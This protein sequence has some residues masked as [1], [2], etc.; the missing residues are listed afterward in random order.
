MFR[1]ARSPQ[2]SPCANSLLNSKAR[3]LSP[4]DIAQKLPSV[5]RKWAVTQENPGLSDAGISQL[6]LPVLFLF[7]G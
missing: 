4:R 2:T 5:P 1:R 6:Q 3:A 7:F